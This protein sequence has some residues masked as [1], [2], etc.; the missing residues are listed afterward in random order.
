MSKNDIIKDKKS[1]SSNNLQVIPSVS[2]L[3][4][5]NVPTLTETPSVIDKKMKHYGHINHETL[6]TPIFS[7]TPTCMSS[8]D[9]HK[10]QNSVFKGTHHLSNTPANSLHFSQIELP[11]VDSTNN[12]SVVYD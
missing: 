11:H 1:A 9:K 10:L 5:I 3:K 12:L 7:L 8:N 6:S 4:L 2:N